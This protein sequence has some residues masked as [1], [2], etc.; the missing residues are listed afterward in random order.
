MFIEPLRIITVVFLFHTF[1]AL[2]VG[3]GEETQG[4]RGEGDG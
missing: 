3:R 4:A 2:T 1:I